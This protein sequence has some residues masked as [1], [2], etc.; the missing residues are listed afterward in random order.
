MLVTLLQNGQEKRPS[1]LRHVEVVCLLFRG[2]QCAY[3]RTAPATFSVPLTD[4]QKTLKKK[5]SALRGRT[6]R[7]PSSLKTRLKSTKGERQC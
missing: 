2:P 4:S 3:E 1:H 5:P 6:E 7:L